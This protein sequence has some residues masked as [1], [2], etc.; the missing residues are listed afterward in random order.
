MELDELHIFE[1]S[2]RP[3]GYRMPSPVATWGFVVRE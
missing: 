1:P 2:A 3:E